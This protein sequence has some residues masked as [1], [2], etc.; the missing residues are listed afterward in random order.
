LRKGDFRPVYV[1]V[2]DS[3]PREEK[4]YLDRSVLGH[5]LGWR[6]YRDSRC[7]FC[8]VSFRSE[9]DT[10]GILEAALEGGKTVAVPRV[11][12]RAHEMRAFVIR[13]PARDLTPGFH[14]I[15][16]P[17]AFCEEARDDAIELVI[18]PGLAFTPRGDRIGYGGG[19]YDRFL[20]MHYNI[21]NCALTYD[22][23]VVDSLPVKE[24]DRAVDYLITETGVKQTRSVAR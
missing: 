10:R 13:D 9:I 3:I 16:E 1:K 23:L 22:R 6:I 15:L 24:H 19:F 21:I 5:L 14:G 7:I 2:R 12:P 4:E 20:K 11:D 17:A 18:A 8:F